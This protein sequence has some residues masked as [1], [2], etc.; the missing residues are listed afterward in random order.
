MSG[1]VLLSQ[2]QKQAFPLTIKNGTSV[3]YP[4]RIQ[5]QVEAGG[6]GLQ[7]ILPDLGWTAA[8]LTF[9][10]S[11]NAYVD[12]SGNTEDKKLGTYSDAAQS[13]AA[14][15]YTLKQKDGTL[16]RATSLPTGGTGSG[17]ELRVMHYEFWVLGTWKYMRLVSTNTAS[18][19]AVNQGADRTVYVKP[20]Y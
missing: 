19:A 3:S 18:T 13:V 11:D 2:A 1:Q 6:R 15:W 4:L 12:P 20:L 7:L 8:D 14:K 17:D 10:F 16:I 9:E 5:D